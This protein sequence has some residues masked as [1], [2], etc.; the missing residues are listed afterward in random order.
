MRIAH[1]L[2]ALPLIMLAACS[3]AS[4]G[5]EENPA[6][7]PSPEPD[8]ATQLD[9]PSPDYA[10]LIVPREDYPEPAEIDREDTAP[11]PPNAKAIGDLWVE[12]LQDRNALMGYGLAGKGPD[13]P[14]QSIDTLLT[15]RE[16]DEWVAENGWTMPR[17]IRW[18]FQDELHFP[19]VSEAA[20]NRIRIWPA[21]EARTGWQLEAALGGKVYMRDGCFYVTALGQ[22]ETEELAWF[23][24]ETGLDVDDEGYMVLR[25]RS[26]GEVKARLGEDM[27]WAGPNYLEQDDPRFA[28]LRKMCGDLPVN[29]VGNPEANEHMYVRYPHLREP[30]VNPPPPPPPPPPAEG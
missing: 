27:T 13:G 7:G 24:A 29:G 8:Y 22:S 30:V 9:A 21:S 17:H 25:E 18:R 28:E 14:I 12:R 23:H 15:A 20:E 10:E 1:R 16:F 3:N 11:M 4:P 2:T 26:T 6:A 5:E 19:R